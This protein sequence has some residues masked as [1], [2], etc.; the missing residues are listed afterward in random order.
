MLLRLP[1]P[2]RRFAGVRLCSDLP[3]PSEL[4]R[5][6]GEWRLELDLSGLDR[7]EYE[8]EVRDGDGGSARVRDPGNPELA[9]GAFGEKSVLLGPGYAAPAWLGREGVDGATQT[10]RRARPRARRGRRDRD[11]EPGRRRAGRAAAPARRA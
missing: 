3:V 7:L 10:V 5:D 6:D 4:A 8:F 11:L 9:P 1:D 2:E